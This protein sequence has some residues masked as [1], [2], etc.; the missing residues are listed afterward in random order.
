VPIPF[1]AGGFALWLRV[2]QRTVS[3]SAS[4]D[5]VAHSILGKDEVVAAASASAIAPG[6]E[7]ELIVAGAGVEQVAPDLADQNVGAAAAEQSVSSP[8]ARQG[9]RATIPDERVGGVSAFDPFDI[10][11]DVVAL[12]RRSVVRSSVK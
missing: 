1:S 8:T 11:P 9:I 5:D 10:R 4:V 7:N 6:V 3:P 2:R 12:A